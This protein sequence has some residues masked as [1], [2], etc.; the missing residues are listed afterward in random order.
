M[1]KL[2]TRE[3]LKAKL[4]RGDAFTLVMALDDWAYRMK[5]IPGSIPISAWDEMA[6]SLDEDEEI[7]VY[8]AGDPCPSST[9]AYYRLTS[10]GFRNVRR[11]AGG[12]SGWEAAGYPLESEV[13]A[14]YA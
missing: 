1:M 10:E 5:H 13:Q 14:V 11:Y 8:C 7:V 6:G 9:I 2:I 4:D 3:E 12:V